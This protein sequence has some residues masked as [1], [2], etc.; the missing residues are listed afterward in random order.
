[1]QDEAVGKWVTRPQNLTIGS[2]VRLEVVRISV[3]V[4]SG[5]TSPEEAHQEDEIGSLANRF[6]T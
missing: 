3:V 5:A 2:E 1:M 6:A 4:T